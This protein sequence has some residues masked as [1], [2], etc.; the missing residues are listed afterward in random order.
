[1]SI[2]FSANLCHSKK[3]NDIKVETLTDWDSGIPVMSCNLVR[4]GKS[5][6]LIAIG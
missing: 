4:L 6:L 3:K 2:K 1:M 5:N